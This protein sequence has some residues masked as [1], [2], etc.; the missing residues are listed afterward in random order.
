MGDICWY[1]NW[2]YPRYQLLQ[3]SMCL[4]YTASCRSTVRQCTFLHVWKWIDVLSLQCSW[5]RVCTCVWINVFSFQCSMCEVRHRVDPMCDNAR[6]CE[7]QRMRSL[8]SSVLFGIEPYLQH[9]CAQIGLDPKQNTGLGLEKKELTQICVFLKGHQ[10]CHYQCCNHASATI[11]I[12]AFIISS[13]IIFRVPLP[14]LPPSLGSLSSL[15]W[16]PLLS[17]LPQCLPLP[18]GASVSSHRPLNGSS[19][20]QVYSHPKVVLLCTHPFHAG[21]HLPYHHHHQPPARSTLKR[22]KVLLCTHPYSHACHHHHQPPARSTP[23]VVLPFLHPHAHHHLHH[24]YY[25]IC[26]TI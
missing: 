18:L 15:P 11:M 21:H 14:S 2:C 22:P 26:M 7:D 24:T 9:T 10:Y 8:A 16:L 25:K 13:V 5:H 1:S 12:I 17:S 20:S 3:C 19:A 6:K 23:K 4:V